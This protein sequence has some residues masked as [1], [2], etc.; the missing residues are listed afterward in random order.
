MISKY[1]VYA[2]VSK[3]G[4]NDGKR[5]YLILCPA[6]DVYGVHCSSGCPFYEP[7]NPVYKW[8]PRLN[9]RCHLMNI[10]HDM[11]LCDTFDEVREIIEKA[12]GKGE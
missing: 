2:N 10:N 4:C 6:A 3:V 9:Y 1:A 11:T 5:R 12:Y 7:T 8:S